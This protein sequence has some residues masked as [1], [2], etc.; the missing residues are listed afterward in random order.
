VSTKKIPIPIIQLS[1]ARL[2]ITLHFGSNFEFSKLDS[3]EI[4]AHL[5]RGG[6]VFVGRDFNDVTKFGAVSGSK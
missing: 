6:V 2:Q 4:L 1:H 5:Y 3:D